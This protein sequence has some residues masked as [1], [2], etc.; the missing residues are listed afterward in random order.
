MLLPKGSPHVTSSLPVTVPWS[1]PGLLSGVVVLPPMVKFPGVFPPFSGMSN[2]LQV[3]QTQPPSQ[4][5][6]ANSNL[7]SPLWPSEVYSWNRRRQGSLPQLFGQHSVWCIV[8]QEH[9]T[10]ASGSSHLDYSAWR[11]H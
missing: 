8:S 4:A 9:S 2:V 6:S 3:Q 1:L 11:H 5:S 7:R 10:S